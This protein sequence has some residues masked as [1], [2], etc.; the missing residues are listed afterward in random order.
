MVGEDMAD[1][2]RAAGSRAT[3]DLG[4]TIADGS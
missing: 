3:V 1:P 2:R 4:A